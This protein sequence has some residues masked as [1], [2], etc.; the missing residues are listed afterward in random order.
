VERAEGELG[1]YRRLCLFVGAIYL[2]WWAAVEALLPHAYNP[3]PGRLGIVVAI[4]AIAAASYANAWVRRHVRVLW[5]CGLWLLT[6]HYFYL[7]Y[8]N[9]G[10][11][12]WVIGSFITVTAVSLAFMSRASLIAFSLFA[13]ALAI[14][15]VIA[16]PTMRSSVF[17]PGLLTVLLQANIGLNSRLGVLRDL[18]ASNAHFELL[19][20]ST[21]EGV[22]IHEAGRV[23]QVNDALV[24]I[25][26]FTRDDLVG[27]DVLALVHPDDR[28]AA[29][30]GLMSGG[31]SLVELRC[32]RNDGSA[33]DVEV[34]GKPFADGKRL[35]TIEDV[36]ERKQRAAELRRTN[37][38]LARSNVDLQRFAY[39]AS[40]DLQTPLRSIASFVDLLRSTYGDALDAQGKDWLARTSHSVDHL[41]TLIR[42]LLEYSRV[43]TVPRAFEKVAMRDALD[44]ATS[45][46]DA[47]VRDSNA[48]IT[49]DELPEVLGDRAQLV[50]LLMNLVDNAIKYHGADPPLVHIAAKARGDDWLFEVRDNGI[51][52]APKHHDQ[53]FEVFKRLHSQKEYQGTGI[54]LAICRR[55]V[56]RHSGKIWVESKAGEGS[57]F[58]FTI[59]KGMA[60]QR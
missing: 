26:G 24:R 50:Q 3:L 46:L 60:T 14:G 17:V 30:D 59:S 13:A 51:G 20:D 33:V 40:H 32:I 23:T 37:E 35:V 2:V 31:A 38:A 58:Y 6:A 28:T 12:N 18:A 44:R 48:T 42:D 15:L 9:A 43:D 49:A 34:R 41:Q 57:A 19:F 29:L 52:I 55:V 8:E 5:M 56:D 11:I 4:W 22:L 7:F 27:R 36:S 47:A 25:L 10:D 54:G 1:L 16:I 39:I 21:F 53:V 45:L